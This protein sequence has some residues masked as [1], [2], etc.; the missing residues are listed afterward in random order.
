MERNSDFTNRLLH[1]KNAQYDRLRGLH[2]LKAQS[3]QLSAGTT[4][5]KTNGAAAVFPFTSLCYMSFLTRF[6]EQSAPA[7]PLRPVKK[8]RE[9]PVGGMSSGDNS[10]RAEHRLGSPFVEQEFFPASQA[11]IRALSRD[12][13][14]N[15]GGSSLMQAPSLKNV[16]GRPAMSSF[17]AA[18]KTREPLVGLEKIP[19]AEPPPSAFLPTNTN[20][21]RV[22]VL[23]TPSTALPP[24]DTNIRPAKRQHAPDINVKVEDGGSPAKRQRGLNVSVKAEEQGSPAKQHSVHDRLIAE[25]PKL[26]DSLFLHGTLSTV[27]EQALETDD[28]PDSGD[29]SQSSTDSIESEMSQSPRCDM[30]KLR[31]FGPRAVAGD[32]ASDSEDNF[33]A[34]DTEN[35]KSPSPRCDMIKLRPFGPRAVAGDPASDSEDDS[36]T[37]NRENQKSPSPRCDMIKLRPFGPRAV[38]GDPDS[39][40]EDYSSVNDTESQKSPSPR[41]DSIKPQ[42]FGLRALAAGEPARYQGPLARPYFLPPV[43]TDDPEIERRRRVGTP[44]PFGPVPP[45]KITRAGLCDIALPPINEDGKLWLEARFITIVFEFLWNKEPIECIKYMSMLYCD[46]WPSKAGVLTGDSDTDAHLMTVQYEAIRRAIFHIAREE[47]GTMSVSNALFIDPLSR[48]FTKDQYSSARSH[49][50]D[51]TTINGGTV[52]FMTSVNAMALVRSECPPRLK[53]YYHLASSDDFGWRLKNWEGKRL[54]EPPAE[55]LGRR[56]KS[57]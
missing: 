2:A 4:A 5:T 29:E 16:W 1:L 34:N 55:L 51:K 35:Q 32:S 54:V 50:I 43:A 49:R 11:N 45:F 52:P 6:I 40:S 18:R 57:A 30:I 47:Y 28:A 15:P 14:F 39:D 8:P 36:Y 7:A 53:P 12:F 24:L 33:S 46:R 31:P 9:L 19:R 56:R 20:G 27:Y 25:L 10:G 17:F 44:E 26:E 38:A 3:S 42:R 22:F 37:N 23:G 48:P 41:C 21:T 13:N